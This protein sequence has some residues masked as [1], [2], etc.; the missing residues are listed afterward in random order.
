MSLVIFFLISIHAVL[1]TK[2]LYEV[3]K[4]EDQ[5]HGVEKTDS[6]Y[7]GTTTDAVNQYRLI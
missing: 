4:R 3:L 5:P 6:G 1:A 2:K 7:E